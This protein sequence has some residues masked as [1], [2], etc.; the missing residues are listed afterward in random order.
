M[1]L[2]YG[3]VYYN[4]D[5]MR[6]ILQQIEGKYWEISLEKDAKYVLKYQK[7]MKLLNMT[8]NSVRYLIYVAVT[9]H[10]V[11]SVIERKQIIQTWLPFDRSHLENDFVFAAVIFWQSVG[12]FYPV[13]FTITEID[14]FFLATTGTIA[15]Q[16]NFIQHALNS[17]ENFDGD[18]KERVRILKKCV[19]HYS[20]LTE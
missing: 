5:K 4:K 6:L 3:S 10:G 8:T 13:F 18:N 2:K 19:D 20:T 14:C 16:M 1:I 17:L 9:V 7:N 11:T 12:Y 15:L